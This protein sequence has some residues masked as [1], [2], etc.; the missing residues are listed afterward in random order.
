MDFP[1]S[2]L[3]EDDEFFQH[4]VKYIEGFWDTSGEET[5]FRIRFSGRACK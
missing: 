3:Y 5:V 1:F 2:F 4:C